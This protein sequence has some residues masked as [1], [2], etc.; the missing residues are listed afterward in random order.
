MIESEIQSRLRT[1]APAFETQAVGTKSTFWPCSVR[2]TSAEFLERVLVFDFVDSP[3]IG[4]VYERRLVKPE[5][6]LELV[7][8]PYRLPRRIADAM[9][10]GRGY[11]SNLNGAWGYVLT[12]KDGSEAPFMAGDLIFT[13]YPDGKTCLDVESGVLDSLQSSWGSARMFKDEY[14]VC[15]LSGSI[16]ELKRHWG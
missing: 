2:L 9:E 11:A 3:A 14:T 4:L 1:I 16:P 10:G 7:E 8:S 6:I 5:A 13:A 15:C 12:F